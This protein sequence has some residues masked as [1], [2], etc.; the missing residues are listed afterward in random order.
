MAVDIG[1]I[2]S[3]HGVAKSIAEFTG[4]LDSIEAK[5]ERLVQSELNA[6]L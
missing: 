2:F 1:L 6:G 4:V 3:A 5:V